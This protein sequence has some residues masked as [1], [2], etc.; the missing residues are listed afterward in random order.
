MSRTRH[1]VWMCA[2]PVIGREHDHGKVDVAD[3][4]Q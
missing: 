2:R 3:D 4:T 1:R